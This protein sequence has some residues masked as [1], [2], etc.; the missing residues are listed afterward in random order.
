MSEA[1][2]VVVVTRLAERL[3]AAYEAEHLAR[4]EA[5]ANEPETALD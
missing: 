3:A 5:T 2:R 1:R 4:L